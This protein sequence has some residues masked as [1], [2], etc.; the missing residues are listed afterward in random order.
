[1]AEEIIIGKLIIDTSELNNSMAESKKAIVDLE[2]EQKKLKKD[3]DNLS[4]ANDQQL[5]T[6]VDNETQLKKMKAEYSANQKSVLDLTKAQTGLDSA[7]AQQNKTQVEAANNT[8]ALTDARKLIDATTIDGAKAIAQINAKIDQNNKFINENNSA[9]EKQKNNVGNY[10]MITENLSNILSKQGGIY[11]TVRTQ[12]EG[13]RST[14]TTSI[15]TVKSVHASVTNA[16]QGIIGFGNASKVAAVQSQTLAAGETA[17][18]VATEG[19]ATAEGTATVASG[20]LST[21]LGALLFPITAIIAVGLILYNVFKDYAPL[22]NPIKDA[23]AALGSVFVVIKG[24]IFDLVTGAKS[25]SDVFSTLSSD[26]VDATTETYKLEGAQRSLAKAMSAQE[27]A[28]AR[29]ATKVKEL[30]LQSKNLSLTEDQR[31]AKLNE[32]QKLEEGAFQERFKLYKREKE[33]AIAKLN[34]SRKL[35]EDDIQRLREG[36]FAYAQKI[37]KEKKLNKEALEDLKSIFLKRETLLQEDNQIQEKAQNYKNKI[38][39]KGNA[40]QEK[41]TEKRKAQSEKDYQAELK[42]AQ[43]AIDILRLQAK[44]RNLSA[45]QRITLAQKIFDAENALAQKSL[46]G[47]DLNKKLIENRQALSSQILAITDEQVSKELEAQKRI[48]ETNKVTNAE[49]YDAQTKSAEDLAK[50]Q[51]LLLD[52]KLLSEKDYTAEVIRINKAKDESLTLVQTQFDEAEK[53]RRETEAANARAFEDVLFQIRLQDIQDQNVTEQEIKQELLAE[54]YR[55]EKIL[56]DQSL[57][58]KKISEETYLASLALSKKKFDSETK[59]NDKALAD[60]KRATN[61]KMVQDGI[62]AL[63]ALFGESKALSIASALVNTYEGIT[64]A[65]DA[66]TLPERIIGV[67]FAVATGFAA[68]KNILK[69]EKGSTSIDSS[70]SKP[71]TTSGSGAFVN[72]AQTET[73]ARVSEKPVEQNTVVSPPVLVLE[74]LHEVENNLLIKVESK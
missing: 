36:D 58:D 46:T 43:S 53:I 25:L 45:E 63:Q 59:K 71:Q 32:A 3:T 73:I 2:N 11:S 50:A 14:L 9:L 23:F 67:T 28:S 38:I 12:V 61:V 29:T 70:S 16:A 51:I 48:L 52:K 15:D 62:G 4:G 56:L 54:N 10:G 5:Q 60:Q 31:V 49:Q 74:S 1:M 8:K 19:L 37:V 7:L 33:I 66:K 69:T 42:Q 35:S 68:V 24:A 22:I 13:F 64:A 39:E 41:A 20:A 47:S 34:Q 17:A 44:E 30:I 40:A 72:T 27:V 57:A 26:I 21:V 18:A 55:Q 65:L 6:F